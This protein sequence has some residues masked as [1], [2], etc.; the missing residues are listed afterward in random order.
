[1]THHKPPYTVN[2][3]L[4]HPAASTALGDESNGFAA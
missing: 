1:L 2:L 4:P 3:T